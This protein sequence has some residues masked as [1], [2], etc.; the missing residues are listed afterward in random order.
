MYYLRWTWDPRLFAGF[1][2]GASLA[3]ALGSFYK[4]RQ[5]AAGG[6]LVAVLLGGRRVA[7]D[8]AEPDEQKLRNVVE[9][10]AIASGMP[11]PEIYVLD[12]ERGINAFAAGHTPRAT[13][14]S[15]SRAAASSC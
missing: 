11:V 6:P 12:D 4:I 15:A 2:A 8:S 1:A 9:E 10:M 13:W 3:I 5:L 7:P 14:P